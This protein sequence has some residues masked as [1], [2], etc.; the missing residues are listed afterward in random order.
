MAMEDTRFE[1]ILLEAINEA[2]VKVFGSETSRSVQFYID[3]NIALV[4]PNAYAN[5]LE[6]MFKDGAKVVLEAIIEALR[7]RTGRPGTGPKNFGDAISSLKNDL[8]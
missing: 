7:E 1:N 4:D 2:L 8:K 3:P 6:K 5:S